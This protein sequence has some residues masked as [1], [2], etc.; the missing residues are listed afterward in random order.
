MSQKLTIQSDAYGPLEH[1]LDA[2]AGW[3]LRGNLPFT[4][5]DPDMIL[6]QVR[7]T[8]GADWGEERFMEVFRVL[9]SCIERR[10]VTPLGRV[11]LHAVF[12][13]ALVNRVRMRRFMQRHPRYKDVSLKN[14][15]FIVGFPRTGTTT[16]QNLLAC[17]PTRHAPQYWE[18]ANP[19]PAHD[20]PVR[21][22]RIRVN[23]T[24]RLL[25]AAYFFAPEQSDIHEITA[26]SPEEDWAFTALTFAVIN[27]AW[28]GIPEFGTY[29]M[30][31]DM[32]WVYEELRA[33]FQV[34]MLQQ[35]GMTLVTKCPDHLW[36]LDS[37]LTVFPDACIV[38]TH[39]DPFPVIASYCS[40]SS[41]ARRTM[42]GRADVAQI[43]P[44]ITAQFRAGVDRAM[45]V[46]RQVGDDR[47]FDVHLEDTSRDPCGV[48]RSICKHFNLPCGE[49]TEQEMQMW[50]LHNG[51]RDKPGRHRYDDR[52]FG[53]VREEV[54]LA[55]AD[56]VHRY[57]V[58]VPLPK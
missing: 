55:F 24:R 21:D 34:L 2:V 39:R 13:K 3:A 29:L 6:G 50:A 17:G 43:G 33:M 44:D 22:R 7:R 52:Q 45:H 31:R 12:K 1:L 19:V 57:D 25:R 58:R 11:L 9:V 40:L 18:L 10:G 8:E 47:F 42:R 35:P 54:D 49:G 51:R 27:Y 32:V 56:Y 37:L 36:F 28:Q 41:L 15:V 38:W 4:S 23:R 14:P 5:L 48:V 20:D 16:L 53:L 30:E 26:T 46:R